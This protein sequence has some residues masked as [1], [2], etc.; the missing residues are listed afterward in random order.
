MYSREIDGEILTLSAGGWTYGRTFV[1]FDYETES[2]WYHLQGFK[3]HFQLKQSQA[4][5]NV[6]A[7]HR[8]LFNSELDLYS[9][10]EHRQMTVP[11]DPTQ[12][13]FD[14]EQCRGYPAVTL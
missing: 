14:V 9:L 2:L 11:L 4:R 3:A 5:V 13:W 6:S 10:S 7:R 1:L 8:G 12:T